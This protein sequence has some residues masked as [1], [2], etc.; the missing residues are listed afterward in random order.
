MGTGARQ[1]LVYRRV[2]LRA[3][4]VL[5]LILC[6]AMGSTT[7]S[8]KSG[9]PVRPG[10]AASGETL[11]LSESDPVILAGFDDRSTANL[12]RALREALRAA[13]DE[14]PYLNLIPD[15]TT[16]RL[17]RDKTTASAEDALLPMC[18][19]TRA[20]A[21]ITGTIGR[22]A[23]NA[24]FE[25]QLSAIHCTS[26]AQLAT[27]RFTG[28][29]HDLIDQL[30]QAANRLRLDLGEPRASTVRFGTRLS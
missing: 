26:G 7:A 18:R 19:I 9:S 28:A 11:H 25:G 1:T 13:L 21:Y 27:E 5:G 3:L 24:S 12:G 17:L 2:N 14:S 16:E 4:A 6:A 15:G 20:K 10:T 30:G 8:A 29:K 22:G 23:Q